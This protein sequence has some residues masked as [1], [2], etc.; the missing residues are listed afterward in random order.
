MDGGGRGYNEKRFNDR[1]TIV[2]S[3][4]EKHQMSSTPPFPSLQLKSSIS[5]NHDKVDGLSA[6]NGEIFIK[7]IVSLL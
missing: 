1:E 2:A 6:N 5:A 4:Y 7:G 3:N